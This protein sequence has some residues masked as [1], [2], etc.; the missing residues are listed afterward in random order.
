MSD[1]EDLA[2][3]QGTEDVTYNEKVLRQQ[4]WKAE[5]KVLQDRRRRRGREAADESAGTC[6]DRTQLLMRLMPD[7]GLA[8]GQCG[9]VFPRLASLSPACHACGRKGDRRARVGSLNRALV[10]PWSS[11]TN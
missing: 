10:L 5:Q 8:D 9:E 2:L 6:G 7:Q 3:W 1:M 11:N 4:Q